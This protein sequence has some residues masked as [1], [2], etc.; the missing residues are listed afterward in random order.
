MVWLFGSLTEEAPR[1]VYEL[2]QDIWFSLGKKYNRVSATRKLDLQHKLQGMKKGQK[3]M[4]EYLNDLKSVCDQLDSFGCALSEQEGIYG[5]LGG[6]GKE[7]EGI[8]TVIEHSMDSSTEMSFEDAVFKLINFDDK[9]QIHTESQE[10]NPHLAFHAGRGYSYRGRGSNS[11]GGGYRGRGSQSYS[12]RGRGFQQ[13]FSDNSNSNRRP[14]CQFCGHYGHSAAKC[15]NRFDQEFESPE[16]FHTAFSTVK[17]SDREQASGQDWF[18]DSA[19]S[20]H[21]TNDASQLTSS[22]PYIG[23]DQVI[24]GEW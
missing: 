24:V 3:T 23:N 10:V 2:P 1:S 16:T 19:A 9:L 14:T 4:T 20:A 15:Y 5:A 18:P 22:Q 13:Q 6:L 12:T 21:I 17:L 8:C 11:N 7:Y